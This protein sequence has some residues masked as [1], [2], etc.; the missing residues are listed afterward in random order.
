[1]YVLRFTTIRLKWKMAFLLQTSDRQT[2][3]DFQVNANELYSEE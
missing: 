2:E 1:M 3:S